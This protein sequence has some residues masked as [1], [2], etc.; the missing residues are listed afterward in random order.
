MHEAVDQLTELGLFR[1]I[2]I[3][4]TP[5]ST[6]GV[7]VE[8]IAPPAFRNYCDSNNDFITILFLGII[9]MECT[10]DVGVYLRFLS[11]RL[12]DFRCPWLQT[13]VTGIWPVVAPGYSKDPRRDAFLANLKACIENQSDAFVAAVKR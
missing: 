3:V 7:Y 4:D 8:V 9:P 2:T 13:V 11:G 6:P 1:G 10:R 5:P 12:P